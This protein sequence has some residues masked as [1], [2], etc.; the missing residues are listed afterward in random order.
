MRDTEPVHLERAALASTLLAADPHAPT[1]CA[2]WRVVDLAAHLVLR[3]RRPDLMA[4]DV[5]SRAEPGR[6]PHLQRL[7]AD[8]LDPVGYRAL[9]ARVAAGGPRWSPMN[10][11]ESMTNL[12]ELVVHHEDV[13]R[14]PRGADGHSG[15]AEP[16][17][18][19]SPELARALWRRTLTGAGLLYRKAHT[20]VVLVVPGGPRAVVWHGADSVAVVG[21]PVELALHSNGRY[22]AAHVTLEGR[23]A[24][25]DR[26]LD[27]LSGDEAGPRS[28]TTP[29]AHPA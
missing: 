26:F 22:R 11:A 12:V 1:L 7:V 20:G 5:L 18:D 9:V 3:E 23:P 21:D 27:G 17:E 4:R 29:A 10:W 25:I 16:R 15:P 19:L 6:E 28:E 13:R 8:A 2:G 24:T 14:G